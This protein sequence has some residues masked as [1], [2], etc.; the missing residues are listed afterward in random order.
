VFVLLLLSGVSHAT[1]HPAAA[2]LVTRAAGARW[3]KAA[4]F[5][6]TGGELGR[7]LGPL[8]IAAVLTAVG[9]EWSWIALLP[10]VLISLV[11]Y[12][13]LRR[14]H[15]DHYVRPAGHVRTA[16]RG[17]RGP[18]IL[19]S[20]A[21]ATRS[22]ANTALVTF[23]P[24]LLLTNHSDL[25]YAG[26]AIAVYEFGATAGVFAGG[27]LSDRIGRRRVLAVSMAAGLPAIALALVAPPG[28]LQ[29]AILALAGFCLLS[30]MP[31]QLVTMHELFPDN[32][33]MA[34]GITYFTGT[35]G[36]IVALIALGV[37]ADSIG[38]QAAL[39]T[40]V[41]IAA[42]GMLAILALP[43]TTAPPAVHPSGTH[44]G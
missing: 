33:A 20:V 36:G 9:I 41:A 28:P 2:S 23:L 34:T 19:L 1:F 4:S 3:G 38:L 7:A 21:I 10:G 11:L 29:L 37:L 39:L 17:N 30:A 42:S 16:F 24:T 22:V 5:F 44:A 32:R 25:V 13:R 15:A 35:G 27:T 14:R 43:R 31:V 12:G 26:L 6:M 40:G 18:V 8:Y